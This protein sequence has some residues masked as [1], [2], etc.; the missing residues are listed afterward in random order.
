MCSIRRFDTVVPCNGPNGMLRIGC[1][2]GVCDCMWQVCFTL[3]L[4][5]VVPRIHCNHGSSHCVWQVCFALA[6]FQC[7]I[8]NCL[9]GCAN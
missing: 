9:H 3:P 2:R 5:D 8:H 6:T 1:M 4:W 7:D